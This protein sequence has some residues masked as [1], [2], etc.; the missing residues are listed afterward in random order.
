LLSVKGSESVNTEGG[1]RK[2]VFFQALAPETKAIFAPI[3]DFYGCFRFAAEY[4][5]ISAGW[6]F[7]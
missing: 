2:A 6:I 5:Y 4:E 1:P 3:E 7:S